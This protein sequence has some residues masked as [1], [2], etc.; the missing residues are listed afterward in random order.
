M[1]KGLQQTFATIQHRAISELL[2][3]LDGFYE[4]LEHG[5]FELAFQIDDPSIQGRCAAMLKDLR[6]QKARMLRKFTEGMEIDQALWMSAATS[7]SE[8]DEALLNRA[9]S[10]ADK[11]AEHFDTVLGSIAG[12]TAQAT[13]RDNEIVDVPIGPDRVAYN[14]LRCFGQALDDPQLLSLLSDLFGRLVLDRLGPLYGQSNARLRSTLIPHAEYWD[15]SAAR[16]E[17]AA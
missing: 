2:H 9:R 4:N 8:E 5:L 13:D 6:L 17:K 3:L 14:F 12:L 1:A 11:H 10:L 7:K 15:G 16:D